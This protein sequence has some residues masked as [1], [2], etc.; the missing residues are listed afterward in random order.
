MAIREREQGANHPDIA[1][2]LDSLAKLYLDQKR[3]EEAEHIYK[4]ALA[5]W[6]GDLKASHPNM[7][8]SLHSLA[9]LYLYQSAI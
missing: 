4:Q 1:T 8:T 5:I 6:E 9:K 7:A 2:S 3:C